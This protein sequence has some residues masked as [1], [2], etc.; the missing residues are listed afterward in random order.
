MKYSPLFETVYDEPSPVGKIGRGGHYSVLSAVQWF[1]NYRRLI[2]GG[3]G[4]LQRFAIIWDEDHDTRLIAAIENAYMRGIMSP[5]RFI[6]E[7]K[8]FLTILVDPEF[9]AHIQHDWASYMI[10][11]KD[12]IEDS[13]DD[14]WEFEIHP[15]SKPSGIIADH[16][17]VLKIYLKNIENLWEIGLQKHKS[18]IPKAPST[19]E[20]LANWRA[21][22]PA[23]S[24][25]PA[26]PKTNGF[27]FE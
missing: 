26:A 15:V 17:E 16:E 21:P 13:I 7:R 25:S 2:D 23:S 12:L 19:S 3:K 10:S 14:S 6:G 22:T 1:D 18:Q 8:G 4:V 27:K 24:P 20:M 9:Y 11:W 5:V